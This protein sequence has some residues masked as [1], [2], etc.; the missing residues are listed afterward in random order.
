VSNPTENV[1]DLARS[2]IRIE[3]FER[4]GARKSLIWPLQPMRGSRPVAER[5]FRER[6]DSSDPKYAIRFIGLQSPCLLT[7]G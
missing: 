7:A 5:F 3:G 2:E 4:G 1:L 6:S